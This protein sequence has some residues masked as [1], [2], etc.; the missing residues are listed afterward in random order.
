MWLLCNRWSQLC[1]RC[2]THSI[3]TGISAVEAAWTK[4][5][6]GVLIA[7]STLTV[8]VFWFSSKAYLVDI[9]KTE[10]ADGLLESQG[11]L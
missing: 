11:G 6:Q 4:C 9:S 7:G 10:Y 1:G 2:F 5:L 8:E 3:Y